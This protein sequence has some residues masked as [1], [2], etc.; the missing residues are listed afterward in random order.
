MVEDLEQWFSSLKET[1][2]TAYLAADE[3]WKQSGFSGPMERWDACRRPI[4]DC[5]DSDGSFLDIGCANGYLLECVLK[6]TEERGVAVEPWGL[7]LSEKLVDLA[8]KRLPHYSDN[9][10]VGNG[11]TWRPPRA[12]DYVRTELCDV[13]DELQRD[14]V[15]RLLE[16]LLSPGGRLLVAEYRSRGDDQSKP[17]VDEILAGFGFDVR[18]HVSGMWEGRELTRVVI[19][20]KPPI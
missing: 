6:W 12:F 16:E 15:V 7:D 13:P 5:I 19:L 17:W 14:H 9:L 11:L 8:K 4:A 10:H 18:S 20:N 3:P 1:L 2:E